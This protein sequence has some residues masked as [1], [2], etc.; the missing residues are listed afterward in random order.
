MGEL[1]RLV[2]TILNFIVPS[3]DSALKI[4]IDAMSFYHEKY[5]FPK[6]VMPYPNPSHQMT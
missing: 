1:T 6:S 2:L 5:S 4:I 3:R